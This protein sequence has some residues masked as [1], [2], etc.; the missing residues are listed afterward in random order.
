M[1]I[2]H[3]IKTDSIPQEKFS[4]VLKSTQSTDK[5]NPNERQGQKEKKSSPRK[6]I[7]FVHLIGIIIF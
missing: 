6:A 7:K 2:N 5:N 1:F 4:P 3:S